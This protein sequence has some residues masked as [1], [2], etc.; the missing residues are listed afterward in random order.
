MLRSLGRTT[1]TT[2]IWI[3]CLTGAL[4]SGI[5]VSHVYRNDG[6]AFV[7]IEAGLAD[8]TLSSVAWADYDTDGDLDILLTGATPIGLASQVYRNDDG[9]FTDIEA[10]L[11][12]V[13]ESSV[14]WGDYDND[15]DPDIL[16]TGRDGYGNS[17]SRLYRNDSGHFTD[18]AAGLTDVGES[19]VA[20][21][22]YDN[23][24]DLDILLTGT[25]DG[26]GSGAVTEIYRNDGGNFTD[27]GVGLP[28][29]FYGSVAWGDYD[30]DDDL[31]ILFSGYTGERLVT[32]IYRNEDYMSYFP[33]MCRNA[34]IPS[35][36]EDAAERDD[37][38][39]GQ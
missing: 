12:G 17:V 10:G 31:D 19:S 28:A 37:P 7:D 2:V 25:Q 1:T 39:G 22:D 9:A 8:A 20:W 35:D 14:A 18:I 24:G 38:E 27:I 26:F 21:G 5:H 30:G 34:V 6:G 36:L 15:G 33:V 13:G 29:V 3:S 11:A 16:L 32:E 23:D 4:N